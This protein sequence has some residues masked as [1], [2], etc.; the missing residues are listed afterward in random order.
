MYRVLFCRLKKI[1]IN[2]KDSNEEE[3]ARRTRYQKIVRENF[4][5]YTIITTDTCSM[6]KYR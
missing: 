3:M 1:I 2:A 4:T 6:S 5:F